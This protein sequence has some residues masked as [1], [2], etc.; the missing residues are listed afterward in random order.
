MN[1]PIKENILMII[2][3]LTEGN[4]IELRVNFPYKIQ[5]KTIS[6]TLTIGK[7]KCNHS[8]ILAKAKFTQIKEMP[9]VFL[10]KKI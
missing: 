1:I 3:K 5:Y 9:W 2:S 8:M 4:L 10:H 6:F 7:A